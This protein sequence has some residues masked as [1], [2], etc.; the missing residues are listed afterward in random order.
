[1]VCVSLGS[2]LG[3]GFYIDDQAVFVFFLMTSVCFAYSAACTLLKL[4]YY[5][6]VRD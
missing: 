4:L 5:H 1:M 2:F 3:A 6:A